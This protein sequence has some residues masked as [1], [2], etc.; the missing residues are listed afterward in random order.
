MSSLSSAT[1]WSSSTDPNNTSTK[2]LHGFSQMDTD[3][4]T[5]LAPGNPDTLQSCC[6]EACLQFL[7]SAVLEQM[8]QFVAQTKSGASECHRDSRWSGR[9]NCGLTCFL[10]RHVWEFADQCHL[11]RVCTLDGG[12]FRLQK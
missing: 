9:H 10:H 12:G 2:L 8:K 1:F 4:I 11:A 7:I 6:F 5:S 3:M